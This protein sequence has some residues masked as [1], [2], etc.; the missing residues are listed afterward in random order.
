MPRGPLSS[1]MHYFRR[2]PSTPT[3]GELT[4]G[5]LLQHFV[6]RQEEEAFEALLQRHG[7]LVL[8]VCRRVLHDADAA[9][10]AFQATFLVLVRK[11]GSIGK[12]ESV[13][14]WLYGVAHRTALKARAEAARRHALERKACEM[15]TVEPI[16]DMAWYEL[17]PVL[18]EE[19]SRLPEKYRAPVVL[20]Y[21]Q[22][23]TNTEAA[24]LLGW[25]KG[26]VS[27][28][29]ARARDLLRQRLTRRGLTLS[30]GLFVTALAQNTVQ[31][32]VPTQLAGSTLHAAAVVSG[33]TL[34]AA[35]VLPAPVAALTQ[36]VLRAMFVTKLKVA[37][38]ALLAVCVLGAGAGMAAHQ[39]L[40]SVH[41]DGSESQPQSDQELL[42]GTWHVVSDE[43]EG[44][45]MPAGLA[46]TFRRSFIFTA[47]KVA[48]KA[49]NQMND[50][51]YK[52]DTT[53]KPKEIDL[54]VGDDTRLG[55]YQLEGK[56]LR[57]C[58]HAKERPTAF[59][60]TKGSRLSLLVLER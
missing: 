52:L 48:L 17:R 49:G 6:D 24:R 30:A 22:G 20:C 26:T 27:G 36:G 29:L 58:L 23:K 32:A 40:I 41:G 19:L 8:G 55:I 15:P 45:A 3:A 4:D 37:A 9:D 33:G 12:R 43:A 18:D 60:T 56:T 28:R 21:L 51:V 57:L 46:Q 2:L 35:G 53:K 44:E 47:D 50:G 7:P 38:T 5:E 59:A 13:G 34:P 14:S 25:T 16:A 39:V 10:D 31:A 42:Q 11:A 1:V 54:V